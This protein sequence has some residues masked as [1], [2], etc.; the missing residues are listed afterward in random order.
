MSE[1]PE[2]LRV[3]FVDDEAPILAALKNLLRRE[4]SDW[5][6]A[7]VV[8]GEAALKALEV[9]PYDVVIS[10]ARMPGMDGAEL[11]GEV[12]ARHPEV[13]RVVLS[14]YADTASVLKLAKVSHQYLCKPCDGPTLRGVI[15]RARKTLERLSN[16][17]LRTW[18]ASVESLPSAPATWL[19]L[20]RVV[21]SPT[22]SLDDFSAIVE[23][24]AAMTG[25]LLQLVNSAY[26]GTA[27]RVV[28]VRQAVVFLGAELVKSLALSAHVFGAPSA[29]ASPDAQHE[30]LL[31]ARLARAFLQGHPQADEAFTAALLRD[32]GELVLSASQ[33][34]EAT[35]ARAVAAAEGRSLCAVQ[36]ELMGVGHDEVGAGL[37]DLWGLPVSLVEVAALHHD[38]GALEPG[39]HDLHAAIH[40]ADVMMGRQ[41]LDQKFLEASGQAGNLTRWT[42]VAQ[43][44]FEARPALWSELKLKGPC[45]AT[46]HA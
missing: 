42:S 14:G 6:M 22:S 45:V 17:T 24:D 29:A 25:K 1:V 3:L 43:K 38:L 13:V 11:L 18:L 2:K 44:D 33:P 27:K 37:L 20:S 40:F 31:S 19:E 12:K 9:N 36:R 5:E 30:A 35:R 23:R 16:P 21:A 28:S 10:D 39:A 26:F 4:R 7:F 15:S 46:G 41:P 34:A 8:G 32:V